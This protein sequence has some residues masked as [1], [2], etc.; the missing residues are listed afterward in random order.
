MPSLL[1]S[2][3]AGGGSVSEDLLSHLEMPL[4]MSSQLGCQM[5]PFLE[6]S[7]TA[8]KNPSRLLSSSCPLHSNVDS[9]SP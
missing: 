3:P 8:R 7:E 9:R 6:A 1:V 4:V 5:T 2:L